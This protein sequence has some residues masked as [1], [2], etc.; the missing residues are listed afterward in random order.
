M[1]NVQVTGNVGM[2]FA[3]YQL[4]RQGWNVMPTARNARGID[5]LIYDTQGKRT[6]GIQVKALSKSNPVP[7]GQSVERLMGD[8]W[9]I[10]SNVGKNNE[11]PACFII[12]AG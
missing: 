1:S 12:E 5:L 4:S 6:F 9:V 2:Y 7:L 3:A 11:H 10:V 8:F